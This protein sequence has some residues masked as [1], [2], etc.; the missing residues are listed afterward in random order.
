MMR[1]EFLNWMMAQDPNKAIPWSTC[2]QVAQWI[3]NTQSK[4]S[5]ETIRNAWRKMGFSYNPEF[6]YD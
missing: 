4:I 2:H 5:V 3:I 1:G 6:P